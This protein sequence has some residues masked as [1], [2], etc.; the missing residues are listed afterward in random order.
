M[1][2]VIVKVIVIVLKRFTANAQR[3]P[4]A[5]QTNFDSRATWPTGPMQASRKELGHV[6]QAASGVLLCSTSGEDGRS[7]AANDGLHRSRKS[8]RARS[9]VSRGRGGEGK[10]R[11]G[12]EDPEAKL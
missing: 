6:T 10:A 11:V 2:I 5:L 3:Y 8:R 12:D 9:N 7:S 4:N 1:V